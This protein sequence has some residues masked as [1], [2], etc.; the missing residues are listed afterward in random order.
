VIVSLALKTK[1]N[2]PWLR[3]EIVKNRLSRSL[4]DMKPSRKQAIG[5][6]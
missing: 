3:G 6:D 2:E 5:G 1:P 4:S